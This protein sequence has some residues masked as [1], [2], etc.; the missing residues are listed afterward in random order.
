MSADEELAPRPRQGLPFGPQGLATSGPFP[1]CRLE[2]GY[3]IKNNFSGLR[4]TVSMEIAKT[5]RGYTW[6][7]FTK[8]LLHSP[9]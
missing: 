7:R 3:F 9:R 1:S 2:T 5:V 6:Q 4:Q 8:Y